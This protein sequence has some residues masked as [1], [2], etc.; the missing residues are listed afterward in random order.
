MASDVMKDV[1]RLER[2][3][4][5][6]KI[7]T[8]LMKLAGVAG[9]EIRPN[10]LGKNVEWYT[11]QIASLPKGIDMARMIQHQ[12]LEHKVISE[13]AMKEGVFR[14]ERTSLINAFVYPE[15]HD[16]CGCSVEQYLRDV[17]ISGTAEGGLL[18][19][20]DKKNAN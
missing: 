9:I 12:L 19:V 6:T 5:A 14:I 18:E 2:N 3:A 10:K 8:I 16:Y 1:E 4:A 15:Q 13:I 17:L 11:M 7:E 20:V